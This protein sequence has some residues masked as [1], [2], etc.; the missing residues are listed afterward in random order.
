M[1]AK[2]VTAYV[3]IADH[4]RSAREYGELG[5]RLGGVPVPKKAFYDQVPNL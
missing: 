5:E 3:P 1:R 4:P 2:L